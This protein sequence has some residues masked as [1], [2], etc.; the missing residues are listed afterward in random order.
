VLKDGFTVWE[1]ALWRFCFYGFIL[2]GVVAT[3]SIS[4]VGALVYAVFSIVGLLVF[5]LPSLCSH[6]PYP[7]SYSDCLF[8]PPKLVK[9]FFPYRGARMTRR[10][11]LLFVGITLAIIALPHLWL[12]K[13]PVGL[14]LFWAF[15]LP[16]V[17]MFPIYY[18]RRCRHFGCPMNRVPYLQR[19]G[20]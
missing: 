11:K 17:V 12:L 5:V 15:A 9:T 1:K 2:V 7:T 18:C 16:V 20:P 3:Y 8:L 6:C 10:E 13:N 19:S 4:P 14:L